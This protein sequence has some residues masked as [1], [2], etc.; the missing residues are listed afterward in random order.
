M[1]IPKQKFR[2]IIFQLLFSYDLADPDSLDMSELLMKELSVTRKTMREAQS[3]V[4]R[5]LSSQEEIDEMIAQTVETYH[6]SRVQ[7][8]E[9][10][11]LRLGVYELFMDDEIPE[12]VAISEAMRLARKF[13]SNEAS[14]F[15]NAV[16]D[17][18]WKKAEGRVDEESK[19][20]THSFD[21]LLK[22]EEA[23]REAIQE[24]TEEES[25]NGDQRECPS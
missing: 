13:S 21:R 14:T 20:V 25:E 8:V 22:S 5:I 19:G 6:F 12:K 2:E 16:L 4:E 9:K 24:V 17:T 23:A 1:S 15:V 3:I 10:N 11:I 18:L 7:I